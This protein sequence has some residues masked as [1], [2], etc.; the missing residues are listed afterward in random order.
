MRLFLLDDLVEKEEAD[1]IT[2]HMLLPFARILINGESIFSGFGTSTGRDLLETFSPDRR[3]PA[4]RVLYNGA[5][6]GV[7]LLN[8]R[9]GKTE[10]VEVMLVSENL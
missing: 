4:A 5:V 10:Y 6:D 9:G 1:A 8:E 3:Y 7:V 2:E